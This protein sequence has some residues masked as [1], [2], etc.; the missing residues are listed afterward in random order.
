[1]SAFA[2]VKQS[3]RKNVAD[4][5]KL[6]NLM[7]HSHIAVDG[8]LGDQTLSAIHALPAESASILDD[9]AKVRQVPYPRVPLAPKQRVS[10]FSRDQ[11]QRMISLEAMR[12]GVN[13]TLALKIATIES[14]LVPDAV[15]AT[16][17]SGLYQ[18]TNSAVADVARYDAS[19]YRDS[20]DRLDV[21]WNIEVGIKY[22]KMC[23]RNYLK[24]SP[25]SSSPHDWV[26]TYAVYNLGIGN[27]RKIK[28]G[29]FSDKG[30]IDALKV[31]AAYLSARGPEYYLASVE[32]K[33]DSVIA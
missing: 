30:L 19:L 29:K 3:G 9:F 14:D 27:Y 25:L 21:E 23:M 22:I 13:P 26:N 12:Q 16:G 10:V 15:S 20:T 33:L 11:I 24:I 5:Q 6:I 31:Q 1:M 8:H 7:G 2:P 32:S 4:L 28:A 18:L 17:A